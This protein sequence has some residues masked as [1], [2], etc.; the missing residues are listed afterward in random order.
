M[1]AFLLSLQG[2]HLT[3]YKDVIQVHTGE[4]EAHLLNKTT[5]SGPS[6]LLV[7]HTPVSEPT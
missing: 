5:L 7:N 2:F 4:E 3:P 1:K 6:G